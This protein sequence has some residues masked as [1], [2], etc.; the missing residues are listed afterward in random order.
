LSQLD[1]EAVPRT[2]KW[3]HELHAVVGATF[4]GVVIT[5]ARKRAEERID[6]TLN[7]QPNAGKLAAVFSDLGDRPY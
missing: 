1:I 3:L 4:L 2:L 5:R 6:S 7:Q